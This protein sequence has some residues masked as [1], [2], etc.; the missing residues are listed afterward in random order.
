MSSRTDLGGY[1]A[2]QDAEEGHEADI[3]PK[4]GA[5]K[6]TKNMNMNMNNMD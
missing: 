4:E 3:S 2:K 6:G 1:C 5:G